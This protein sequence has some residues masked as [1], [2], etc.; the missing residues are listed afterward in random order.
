M[1]EKVKNSILKK[2]IFW[3]ESRDEKH[4]SFSG[5]IYTIS[6]Y[7]VLHTPYLRDKYAFNYSNT[8]E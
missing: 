4:Y 2:W 7:A 8:R 5:F 6:F 3:K 1:V